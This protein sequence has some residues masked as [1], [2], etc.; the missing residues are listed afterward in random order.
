MIVCLPPILRGNVIPSPSLKVRF[1]PLT[2]TVTEAL[3]VVRTPEYFDGLEV[4]AVLPRR[5][6]AP[7]LQVIGDVCGCEAEPFGEDL[8]TLQLVGGDIAQPLTEFARLN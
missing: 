3:L 6:D 8:P 5:L 4:G 7:L 1:S 2:S